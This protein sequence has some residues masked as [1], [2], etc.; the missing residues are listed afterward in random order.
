[1][2]LGQVMAIF[3]KV[4]IFQ[5]IYAKNN[6]KQFSGSQ[7]FFRLGLNRFAVDD[8]SLGWLV[9]SCR[10]ES[11]GRCRQAIA[12]TLQPKQRDDPCRHDFSNNPN[13]KSPLELGPETEPAKIIAVVFKSVLIEM[14]KA[15]KLVDFVFNYFF[16]HKF[17]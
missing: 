6:K 12:A 2:L 17:L 15:L 4:D 14:D 5:Q 7:H 10:S 3:L 13:R 8:D 16:S 9:E 1:M 11:P